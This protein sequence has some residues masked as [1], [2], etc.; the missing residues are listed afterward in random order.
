MLC[1]A[2]LCCAV[3]RDAALWNA[4]L[5]NGPGPITLA[6]GHPRRCG[7]SGG[8]RHWEIFG[9]DESG[10][11]R[12][13]KERIFEA[14]M[15]SGYRG[16]ASRW[17]IIKFG[18]AYSLTRHKMYMEDQ[19]KVSK[20]GAGL[21]YLTSRTSHTSNVCIVCIWHTVLVVCVL[22]ILCNTFIIM[23][24]PQSMHSRMQTVLLL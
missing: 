16:R 4:M 14:V 24:T 12:G 7:G 2:V 20:Q 6:V 18:P 22:C 11:C 13:A 3:L 1:C 8:S 21:V 5:C 10:V 15:R 19:T 23:H 17:D 9:R